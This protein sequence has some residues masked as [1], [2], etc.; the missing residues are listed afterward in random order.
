MKIYLV[1]YRIN[2]ENF[3]RIRGVAKNWQRAERMA[4]TLDL[5]LRA[6]KLPVIA[7]GVKSGIHGNIYRDEDLH[8]RWAVMPQQEEN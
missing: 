1:W 2:G 6:E 7:V 8:M 4:Q 5:H 3:D